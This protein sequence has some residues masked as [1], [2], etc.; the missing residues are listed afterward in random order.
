MVS[1]SQSH[2]KTPTNGVPTCH[3]DASVPNCYFQTIYPSSPIV[4]STSWILIACASDGYGY[5]TV[6]REI[7]PSQTATVTQIL[8]ADGATITVQPSLPSKSPPT[9]SPTNTGRDPPPEQGPEAAEPGA[10]P[11]QGANRPQETGT[12]FPSPPPAASAA[13][14][15]SPSKAWIPGAVVGPLVALTAL[16]ILFFWL[17]K[18]LGERKVGTG[19]RAELE[20]HPGAGT[21]PLY[22]PGPEKHEMPVYYQGPGEHP[23]QR[24]SLPP[25]VHELAPAE[26]P[27]QELAGR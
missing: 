24:Y 19:G 14:T 1:P 6:Y 27:P 5:S 25:P 18:R 15:E 8:T 11:D 2:P 12:L 7:V 9:S 21:P 20:Q 16:G 17:G 22:D 23:P 13:A 3:S 4:A 10:D 26:M